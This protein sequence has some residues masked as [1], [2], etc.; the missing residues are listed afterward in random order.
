MEMPRTCLEIGGDEIPCG[1][2]IG[3]LRPSILAHSDKRIHGIKSSTQDAIQLATSFK[4]FTE[5]D[6]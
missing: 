3:G 2:P 1:G 5:I 4:T 6:G